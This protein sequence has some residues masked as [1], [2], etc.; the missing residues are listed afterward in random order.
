MNRKALFVALIISAIVSLVLW[1][2]IKSSQEAIRKANSATQQA[3]VI[4][5]KSVVISTKRLP[6]RTRLQHCFEKQF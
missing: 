3:V 4:P 5:K 6:A 1:S 2:R